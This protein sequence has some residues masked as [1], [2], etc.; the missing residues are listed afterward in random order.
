MQAYSHRGP[1]GTGGG[2]NTESWKLYV[3]ALVFVGLIIIIIGTIAKGA[4]SEYP[5]NG[6]DKPVIA[7]L[8]QHHSG[9]HWMESHLTQCFPDI[10]IETTLHRESYLF[11]N[12]SEF[13][14]KTWVVVMVRNV[15]DWVQLFAE[16]PNTAPNHKDLTDIEFIN[17]AWTEDRPDG[18]AEGVDW[19]SGDS[20]QHDFEYTDVMPC[21]EQA[22]G[23]EATYE[24]K[25][26]GSGEPFKS[27]LDMRAAKLQNFVKEIENRVEGI[28]VV[29]FEKL[30]ETDEDEVPLF[31]SAVLDQVEKWVG[32]GP[33]CDLILSEFVIAPDEP[34]NR[35]GHSGLAPAFIEAINAKTNWTVEALVGYEMRKVDPDSNNDSDNNEDTLAPVTPAPTTPAPISSSPVVADTEVPTDAPITLAPTTDEPTAVPVAEEETPSPTKKKKPH[36]SKTTAPVTPDNP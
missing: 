22:G 33:S 16:E 17:K 26:D 23:E 3:F 1:N 4:G 36:H 18:D 7:V 35:D 24:M 28:L 15:Y 10:T 13:H 6:N 21:N 12:P 19:T 8:G 32:T 2:G 5:H 34:E 9:V 20:C 31:K 11:Q 25:Q 29:H 27:V 30:E 14:D